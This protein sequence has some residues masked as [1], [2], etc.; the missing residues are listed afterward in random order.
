MGGTGQ[1]YKCLPASLRNARQLSNKR[2]LPEADPA[3]PKLADE[4]ART[5]TSTAPI[6]PLDLKLERSLGLLDLALLGHGL[7]SLLCADQ[8]RCSPE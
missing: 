8:A 4:R 3:K 5:P 1:S 2:E 6:V 7:L